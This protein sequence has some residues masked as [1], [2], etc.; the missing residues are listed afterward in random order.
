M[1]NKKSIEAVDNS[2]FKGTFM[3]PL[4][5]S[6]SLANIP[7]TIINNFGGHSNNILPVD[8]FGKFQKKYDKIVLFVLDGF[9]YSAFKKF[10][11]KSTFLTNVVKNGV[12]SKLTTQFPST[13]SANIT[14]FHTGLPV[15]LSGVIEWFY[16]EPV[17]DS[18]YSPLLYKK[19]KDENELLS[20]EAEKILPT[21]NLYQ[22]LVVPSYV[23]Q[24]DLYNQGAYSHLMQKGS[25]TVDFKNLEDGL[26]Q[27]K[28]V[29]KKDEKSYS[30]FYHSDFD[31]VSHKFGPNAKET[32]ETITNILKSLDH[33]FADLSAKN[34]LF[35]LTADHGQ[36]TVVKENAIYINKQYPEILP[37][38]K[39]NKEGE[40]IIPCGSFRD[41]FLHIEKGH[42]DEV[43]TFLQEKLKGKAEVY[44]VQELIEAG[45]FGEHVPSM[46]F[47]EK[48]GDIVILAYVDQAIW[49]YEENKFF[50][51]HQ[52]MH[53]GL[54]KDELEI[55]F[56]V[57][58]Y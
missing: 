30:Y 31:S 28:E 39:K 52:G 46:K 51:K 50:V 13:T 6:Y 14:T 10:Y 11:H 23:F 38:I 1:Y 44:K 36:T 49:W 33:F 48:I 15:S 7:G 53:G 37:Y 3:K 29:L 58:P 57:Y 56:L 2:I 34:T 5:E 27:L 41:M 55:P 25:Q 17:I 42:V 26:S 35:M 16:Y 47:L 43:L 21:E 12:V 19:A 8:V 40:Y 22:Q 18:V 45:I 24:L 20:I 32:E 4:N 54:T 9:G